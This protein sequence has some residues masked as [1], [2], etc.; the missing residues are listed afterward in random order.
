MWVVLAVVMDI[1][2]IDSPLGCDVSYDPAD[3]AR[4]KLATEAAARTEATTE[5]QRRRIHA[6]TSAPPTPNRAGGHDAAALLVL[7]SVLLSFHRRHGHQLPPG[8][9]G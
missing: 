9:S 7:S 8:T 1:C 4:R 2:C 5:L 3:D 6:E